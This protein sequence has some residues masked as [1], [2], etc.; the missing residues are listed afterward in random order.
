MFLATQ[1]S[2]STSRKA[3]PS[4]W[5]SEAYE[6]AHL[7]MMSKVQRLTELD[8]SML[9]PP[10]DCLVHFSLTNKQPIVFHHCRNHQEKFVNEST[11]FFSVLSKLSTHLIKA[12]NQ[13]RSGFSEKYVLRKLTE[14]FYII[15]VFLS[16][17]IKS[18]NFCQKYCVVLYYV[19]VDGI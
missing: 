13:I 19:Q 2:D 8:T 4:F 16:L 14:H 3:D 11:C 9:S 6:N 7:M 5:A 15:R 12:A 17:L 1:Y 10:D 18:M